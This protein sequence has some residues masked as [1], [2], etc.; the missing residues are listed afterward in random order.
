M[1]KRCYIDKKRLTVKR[2]RQTDRQTEKERERERERRK[3]KKVNKKGEKYRERKAVCS[4]KYSPVC[5]AGIP[6]I[7]RGI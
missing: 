6:A 3:K 4:V 2:Q 7:A 5:A 1:R